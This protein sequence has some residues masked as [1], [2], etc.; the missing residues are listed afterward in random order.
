[1]RAPARLHRLQGDD[2][3]NRRRGN[4]IP[5]RSKIIEGNKTPAAFTKRLVRSFKQ[6]LIIKPD[7]H[8]VR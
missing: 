1:M 6:K 4:N 2:R 7:L 3:T 8:A 5:K